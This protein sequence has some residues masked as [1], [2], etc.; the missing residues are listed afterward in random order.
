MSEL[1]RFFN[2]TPHHLAELP[3]VIKSRKSVLKKVVNPK[4]RKITELSFSGETNEPCEAEPI[5]ARLCSSLTD[6]NS[7]ETDEALAAD[8]VPFPFTLTADGVARQ[9]GDNERS[10]DKVEH[11]A[12]PLIIRRLT[13]GA[14]GANYGLLLSAETLDRKIVEMAIPATRLHG[15]PAE[16][17]R[18]L[19]ERGVRVVPSKEKSLTAYLDAARSLAR[20]RPWLTAMLRTGWA[21]GEQMTYV[22]P[23]RVIGRPHCVYQP[24][25]P[26]RMAEACNKNGTLV[27]WQRQI[28]T[29]AYQSDIALFVLCASFAAAL[30]R[31]AN[32][33]S[34][35]FNLAGMTSRGKTTALQIAAS[36]WG[37]GSDP[38]ADSRA[39]VRRWSS[40]GNA[41]EA[42]AEEHS[43]LPLC[44]DELGQFRN[45]AELGKAVYALTGGRGAERLKADSSRRT[46][47]EWRT[48]VLSSGEISISESMTQNGQQQKGGQALRILDLPFPATGLFPNDTNAGKTVRDLK[49]ACTV[50]YGTAGR[51]FAKWLVDTFQTHGAALECIRERRSACVQQLADKELPEIMRAVE[52]FALIQVAGEFAIQAGTLDCGPERIAAAVRAAWG[53]WR[54]AVPDVDD[55][56]RAV[57]RIAQYIAAHPGQF[58]STTETKQLPQTVAGYYKAGD[59]L[60]L[61]TDDALRAAIGDT[62]KVAAIHAL[63]AAGLLFK[64]ETTRQKSKHF[65]AALNQRTY[66]YAVRAQILDVTEINRCLSDSFQDGEVRQPQT[67]MAQGKV[68]DASMPHS[69]NDI[70]QF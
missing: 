23:D 25:Q 42:L 54:N 55:G 50:C 17:A 70:E 68:S 22:L 69:K 20:A 21:E 5:L 18:M 29:P 59:E 7:T 60:Y 9:A 63:E 51:A 47:R 45:A 43:D 11:I 33:D 48:V 30:L 39:Y 65:I 1:E 44:L 37:L 64:N 32:S 19:A 24:A 57:Q 31:P 34:F 13:R 66:F 52:R 40:T 35:G 41:L 49:Q 8:Y 4:K 12:G 62:A 16:L 14:D 36:V 3:S 10:S 15:D 53:M 27:D 2:I 58:P 46:V 56:K 26:N 67:V 28:A 61:L 38:G 6:K